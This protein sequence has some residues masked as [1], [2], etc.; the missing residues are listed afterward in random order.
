MPGIATLKIKDE[1]NLK[2]DGL[3]LD[4]RRALM[5]KFEFEVPGARYMPS[6]KLGRWNG[7]VS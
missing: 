1:V 4:A 5:Q 7:K 6:V 2:I 3:E